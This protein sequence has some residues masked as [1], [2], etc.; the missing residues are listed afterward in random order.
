MMA[1][2]ARRFESTACVIV[3]TLWECADFWEELL[4]RFR[5][6]SCF[7]NIVMFFR[8]CTVLPN[9]VLLC[10]LF[11]PL[12]RELFLLLEMSGHLDR[13]LSLVVLLV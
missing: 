13:P 9:L 10:W 11:V 3:I 1:T 4:F 5:S 2:C 8:D 6:H 12:A 7:L